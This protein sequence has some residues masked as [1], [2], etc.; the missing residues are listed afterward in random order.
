MEDERCINVEGFVPFAPVRDLT[1]FLLVL[2]H[3][4]NRQKVRM[5]LDTVTE[6][7]QVHSRALET[8]SRATK[9][10][11]EEAED[12]WHRS[13]NLL[14]MTELGLPTGEMF[15]QTATLN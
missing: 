12:K 3:K 6:L 5:S 10:L 9:H 1:Y 11:V 8:K 4:S 2:T 14:L 15:E 7:L 13:E